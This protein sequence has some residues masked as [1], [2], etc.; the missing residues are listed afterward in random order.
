ME[1]I[2]DIY[3]TIVRVFQ[4]K[5]LNTRKKFLVRKH[6][7]LHIIEELILIGSCD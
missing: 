7:I 2:S 4:E 6:H 5:L 1:Y 3:D